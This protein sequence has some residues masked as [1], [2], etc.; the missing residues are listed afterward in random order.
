[1]TT[2]KLVS[3]TALV[4]FLLININVNLSHSSEMCNFH[5]KEMGIEW[6]RKHIGDC[7]PD[8]YKSYIVLTSIPYLMFFICLKLINTYKSLVTF[9]CLII[10]ILAGTVYL[11]LEGKIDPYKGLEIGVFLI[12]TFLSFVLLISSVFCRAINEKNEPNSE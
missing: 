12:Q 11:E 7:K 10:T 6:A 8:V 9:S 2:L 3:Y 1:M 4:I 5:V